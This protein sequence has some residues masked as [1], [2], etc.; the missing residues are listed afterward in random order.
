MANDADVERDAKAILDLF[1]DDGGLMHKAALRA[2]AIEAGIDGDRLDR[3]IDFVGE[4]SWTVD[5]PST[6]PEFTELTDE[7]KKARAN[8]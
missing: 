7:G 3:A 8:A 1:P 2:K 6:M 5:G 4:Q